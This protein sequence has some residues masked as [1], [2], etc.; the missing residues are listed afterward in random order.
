MDE[1]LVSRRASNDQEWNNIGPF[2]VGKE[3]E[4]V[5][6]TFLYPIF[7]SQELV[8]NWEINL[9]Q[10]EFHG[11]QSF[12]GNPLVT[13]NKRRGFKKIPEELSIPIIHPSIR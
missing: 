6:K 10:E 3:E 4:E 2:A 9:D 7:D 12:D 5:K 13:W 11:R 1:V 8:H